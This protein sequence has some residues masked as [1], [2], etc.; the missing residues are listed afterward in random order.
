M[1]TADQEDDAVLP[2]FPF[3]LFFARLWLCVVGL[4]PL[5]AG[6]RISDVMVGIDDGDDCIS[7]SSLSSQRS[8]ISEDNE[9]ARSD[10]A[11]AFAGAVGGVVVMVVGLVKKEESFDCPALSFFDFDPPAAVD[12]PVRG[13]GRGRLRDSWDDSCDSLREV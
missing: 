7:I 8:I 3:S 6:R 10:G 4:L 13:R 11:L 2:A 12:V 5:S 1:K 9:T